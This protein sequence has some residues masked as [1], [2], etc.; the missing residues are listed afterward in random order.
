MTMDLRHAAAM[1]LEFFPKDGPLE[2][3]GV[4]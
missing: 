1:L 4:L 2:E 3:G